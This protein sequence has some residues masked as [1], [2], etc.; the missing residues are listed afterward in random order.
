MYH[1]LSFHYCFVQEPICY[2]KTMVTY[3]MSNAY[4]L[5]LFLL[6]SLSLSLF[7]RDKHTTDWHPVYFCVNTTITAIYVCAYSSEYC[8][9][10]C[11]K[12]FVCGPP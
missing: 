2:S 3:R 1:N 9:H 8:H 5:S 6:L 7:L 11:I 10:H 4:F 12:H